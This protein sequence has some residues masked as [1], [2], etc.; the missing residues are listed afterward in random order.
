[1]WTKGGIWAF[2]QIKA[3]AF[4]APFLRPD[5][6]RKPGPWR[7]KKGRRAQ[8]LYCAISKQSFHRCEPAPEDQHP[9]GTNARR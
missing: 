9:P 7:T 8:S 2:R 3:T 6:I 1:M 5:H 4:A